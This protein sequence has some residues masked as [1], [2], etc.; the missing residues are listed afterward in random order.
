MRQ[1]GSDEAGEV[2]LA[3]VPRMLEFDYTDTFVNAFEASDL[4][5]EGLHTLWGCIRLLI[6]VACAEVAH[7]QPEERPTPYR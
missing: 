2:L 4:S 3:L 6:G 5:A 7:R 1:Q